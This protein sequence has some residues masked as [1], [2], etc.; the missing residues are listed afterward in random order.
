MKVNVIEPALRTPLF[1]A[2]F[3]TTLR[4]PVREIPPSSHRF[5]AY[6]RARIFNY[7]QRVF[8]HLPPKNPQ[9][10]LPGLNPSPGPFSRCML[11]RDPG[12]AD[13]ASAML[14]VGPR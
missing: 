11:S 1:D 9:H 12:R 13:R 8:A 3:R 4:R 2:D 6:A 5:N 10:P 14:S 7:N